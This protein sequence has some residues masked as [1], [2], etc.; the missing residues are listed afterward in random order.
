MCTP[1]CSFDNDQ[2]FI[3]NINVNF[4]GIGLNCTDIT[5]ADSVYLVKFTDVVICADSSGGNITIQLQNNPLIPNQFYIIKKCDVS[6]N[7]VTILP[8]LGNTINGAASYVLY[9]PEK[10]VKLNHCGTDW[11]VVENVTNNFFGYGVNCTD[12]TTADSI[13]TAKLTDVVICADATLGPITIQLQNNTDLTGQVYIIKK[14][15]TSGNPITIL[16]PLGQTVNGAAS[17]VICRP[18]EVV[19]LSH[20]GTDWPII[21]DMVERMLT[22]RGDMIVRG[23]DCVYRFPRGL[24]GQF[25]QTDST[26]PLGLKWVDLPSINNTGQDP[27]TYTIVALETVAPT[28]TYTAVGYFPWLF[29]RNSLYSSGVCIIYAEIANRN[30]EIRAQD[31]TNGVT[32]GSAV[33]AAT[34]AYSFNLINAASNAQIELQIRKSAIGGIN[35]RLFGAA[36]EYTIIVGLMSQRAMY[37]L[38][39]TLIPASA[40]AFAPIG[41][42]PW[43]NSLYETYTNGLIVYRT[44]ITDRS[45]DIRLQDTTNAITLGSASAAVTGSYSFPVTN[46]P[47][48]ATVELQVQWSGVGATNPNMLGVN[49]EYI[50]PPLPA[51]IEYELVPYRI[52][53]STVAYTTIGYFAWDNTRYA[54][55]TQAVCIFRSSNIVNRNIDIRVRDLT[56]SVDLGTF[57][58]TTN[59]THVFSVIKPTTN[60]SIA[61]QVRKSAAGGINPVVTG[62]LLDWNVTIPI[63]RRAYSPLT[64]EAQA[65]TTTYTSIGYFPWLFSRYSTYLN[66]TVIFYAT[67]NPSR[68]LDVRIYDITNAVTRGFITSVSSSGVMMFSISTTPPANA[69][70]ALQIRKNNVGGV[71]PR[72]FGATIEFNTV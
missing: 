34:G 71:N 21:E 20:C 11:E 61:V 8:S 17:L 29:A 45:L 30:L 2:L 26:Q 60:A 18:Q 38:A 65:T 6:L 44:Q 19:M 24:D 70:L 33:I 64:V 42:F 36:F 25:L 46:P 16:P 52:D 72:I 13:Y 1:N 58:A 69:L 41:Y 10:V 54:D 47:T 66:G 53:V 49:L 27:V 31:V 40:A 5:V 63:T 56:N 7:T 37:S 3:D 48:D 22:T 50:I 68:T 55:Y 14:C 32:L 39:P 15:D 57:T 9:Q 12:I 35:P 28:T 51:R 43:L 62:I 4:S 59:T 67:L 23:D